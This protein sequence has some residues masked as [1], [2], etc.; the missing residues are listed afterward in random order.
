LIITPSKIVAPV[1][2]EVVLLA[3]L[4]GADG[5]Y[6][7]KQRVEWLLSQES[8]GHLVD[9]GEEH[10]PTLAHLLHKP[11]QKL[12]SNF[13]VSRT[14]TQ[15][16]MITRGTSATTDDLWLQQGQG[17][18]SL[19][20][21]SEGTSHVTAVA[22]EAD[23]WEQRRQTATIQWVDAQWVLPSA[24]VARAGQTQV[25]TTAIRRNSTGVPVPN[26]LV[27]YEV[28]SGPP[29]GFGPERAASA[30]VTTDANGHAA[31]A[32]QPQTTA[33]G[34]TQIRVSILSPGLTGLDGQPV[35]VGQGT[36][37]ITWSAAG[38]GVRIL[39]PQ[40]GA[41]DATLTYE[42]EVTNPGDLAARNVIVTAELPAL[43]RPIAG[44]GVQGA[45]MQWQLASL[46][47]HGSHRFTLPCR[48]V[49]TGSVR[50]F[51]RARAE[52]VEADPASIDTQII[53]SALRLTVQMATPNTAIK[54]GDR[55]SFQVTVSNVG[56]IPLTNVRIRDVY[57]PGLQEL[58]GQA[59]PISKLLGNLAPGASS[60]IAVTFIVRQPGESCHLLEATADG[61]HA[62]SDRK[63]IQAQAA[64]YEMAVEL[65][66]PQVASVGEQPQFEIVVTNTGDS[67]LRAVRILF[68]SDKSLPSRFS[69]A[70]VSRDPQDPAVLHAVINSLLPGESQSKRIACEA[71]EPSENAETR[72]TVSSEQG[73]T[74]AKSLFTAI[75]PA[76]AGTRA[77]PPAADPDA[78][79]PQPPTNGTL[80][81]EI[82]DTADPIKL[83][84]STVYVVEVQ[85]TR[86]ISDKNL[87]ISFFLSEGFKFV[88]LN[89]EGV[90]AEVNVRDDGRAVAMR[91]IVEIRPG[92]RLPALR[93]EVQ[94]Q[95]PGVLWVRAEV[96]S[97]MSER[98][99]VATHQTRV[100]AN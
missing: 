22:A 18:V 25:L 62:A 59:S 94:A 30:A 40:S 90:P 49:N 97:Q 13:A 21:L 73:P 79:L 4:C 92:E 99:I 5:Q 1:G 57:D 95:A 45:N 58:H 74:Q 43:L 46:A 66:G 15:A 42:I 41:V 9:V 29:V 82:G 54:V 84:E 88:T 89:S 7:S 19:T 70:G 17:W 93:L 24:A 56:N 3:G 100:D 37:T 85:N 35:V 14:S 48:A 32:V 83:G 10:H 55:V 2:S 11:P 98:P 52:G 20:S 60:P 64:R 96:T 67:E 68:R 53:E 76:A 38:L 91:P 34:V 8:V 77:A 36:T 47:P 23:N 31:I 65:R 33:P 69:S 26:W 12:S 39:G 6:V 51:V 80:K 78:P 44:E 81:L 50:V 63:C 16:R 72:V 28:V 71:L 87:Q 61:G 27:R 75:R 86:Q